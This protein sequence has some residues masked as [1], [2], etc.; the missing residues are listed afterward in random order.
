[1]KNDTE[2]SVLKW[3]ERSGEIDYLS[4]IAEPDIAII[5]NIGSSHLEH[6]HTR[7]NIMRA[8]IEIVNGLKRGGTLIVNGDES[9]LADYGNPDF[10]TISVG[11]DNA[12]AT[13]RATNIRYNLFNTVFDVTYGRNTYSDIVIP[14][15][16]KHNV[17]AAL[18]AYAAAVCT[19]LDDAVIAG[20]LLDFKPVGMR[21]NIYPL[22]DITV[23]E[24]CYNASPESMKAAIS[25]MRTCRAA[26]TA[27]ECAHFSAI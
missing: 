20:G 15:M 2:V 14:T 3:Q 25:V 1:M 5:T 4:R 11:I 16:G 18:F 26:W 12:G 13:F 8:K 23:I 19:G 22:G 17:Y 24:D 9:L 27:Q 21:Q 6:L 7:E 10:S